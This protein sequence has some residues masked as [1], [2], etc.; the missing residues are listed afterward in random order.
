MGKGANANAIVSLVHD[1]LEKHGKNEKNLMLHADI[2]VGQN[3]NNTF[4]QYITSH[5]ITWRILTKG[6]DTV[7]LSYMLVGHTKFAPESYVR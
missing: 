6:N 2:C 1:Y 3:K 4:M 5:H 7:Q